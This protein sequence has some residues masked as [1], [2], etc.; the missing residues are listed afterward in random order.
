MNKTF[1][2][3]EK[4]IDLING[5]LDHYPDVHKQ[6]REYKT[7][8]TEEELKEYDD[9]TELIERTIIL[10]D[11]NK[12]PEKTVNCEKVWN[13]IRAIEN[14]VDKTD[15]DTLC[16]A[17]CDFECSWSEHAEEYHTDKS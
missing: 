6:A 1:T 5:M 16:D 10:F 7:T 12:E 11:P 13:A 8:E 14:K 2:L 9:S 17:F 15:Y 3:D 4:Q